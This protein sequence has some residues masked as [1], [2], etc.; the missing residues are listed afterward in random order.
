MNIDFQSGNVELLVEDGVI[1]SITISSAGSVQLLMSTAEAKISVD[2]QMIENAA[3][4]TV[5][6]DVLNALFDSGDIQQTSAE[7]K[8]YL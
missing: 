1:Q 5:P 7:G 4:I 3:K 8:G 2:M 6:Q